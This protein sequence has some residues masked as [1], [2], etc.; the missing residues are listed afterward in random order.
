MGSEARDEI[1][2]KDDPAVLSSLSTTSVCLLQRLHGPI[3]SCLEH[4]LAAPT[5]RVTCAVT[6]APVAFFQRSLPRPHC[7][8]KVTRPR[9]L[10][11]MTTYRRY[12]FLYAAHAPK[13]A[14][15]RV[16]EHRCCAQAPQKKNAPIASSIRPAAPRLLL[17][18]PD[19]ALENSGPTRSHPFEGK[20]ARRRVQIEA[21]MFEREARFIALRC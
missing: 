4:R 21:F 11:P 19:Q 8:P 20:P 12:V 13:L 5:V 7:Y 9:G 3:V 16:S 10:M 17:R 14:N 6:A 18:R 15:R 2:A 1:G